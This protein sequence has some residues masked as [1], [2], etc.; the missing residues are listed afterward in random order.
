MATSSKKTFAKLG[1]SHM[2]T[3]EI[4]TLL[5]RLLSNYAVYQQKLRNFYWN[6]AGSNFFEMHHQ[7]EQM[8][9]RALRETDRI[10]KRI[11]LFGQ[12]PLSTF[13]D[14]L[15]QATIN[16]ETARV[17]SFEMANILLLD[18]RT[19]LELMEAG[20]NA[21]Q[22]INDNGTMHML[23]SFIYEMEEDHWMLTAW[24]KEEA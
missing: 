2:D 8:Y 11:R 23:K 6:V 16:E 7:F 24:I 19:L 12:K 5:N 1:Y 15:K 9:D 17:P 14:Y 3:A 21:A 4:V 20:V 22:E 13:S 10:A 18:I